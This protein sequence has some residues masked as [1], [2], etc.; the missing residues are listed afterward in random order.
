MDTDYRWGAGEEMQAM[1]VVVRS[2]SPSGPMRDSHV[3]AL[4]RSAGRYAM[5]ATFGVTPLDDDRGTVWIEAEGCADSECA[6]VLTRQ[7]ALVGF[8]RAETVVL[9]MFR[10]RACATVQCDNPLETCRPSDGRCRTAVVVTTE[11]PRFGAD[12]GSDPGVD[13]GVDAG[14]D[15]AVDTSVD[16]G[17]IMDVPRCLAPSVSCGSVCVDTQTDSVHCGACGRACSA[18]QTCSAGTCVCPTNRTLCSGIC[19]DI[20]TDSSNCGACGTPCTT[21]ACSAGR[22]PG[23]M[24]VQRS[25]TGTP[26]PAGCGLVAIVGGTFTMG[27]PT[28]CTR[29]PDATCAVDAAPEQSGITVG[30]FTLDAYEVTVDRFRAFWRERE[31]SASPTVLRANPIRYRNNPSIAWGDAAQDPLPLNSLCNW[32]MTDANVA[33]H[34]MNCF[35]W[36]LAQ[37]FCAWDGGRLPTEAEW[38]Y[39]ARGRT[40]SGLVTGRLYPWGSTPPS[41]ACDLAHWNN[42]PGTDGRR[43]RRVDAFAASASLYGLAGSVWEWTAD[44]HG[45]YPSCRASTTNPLCSNSATGRR[46]AR[47]GSWNLIDEVQN[48]RSASRGTDWPA[49]RGFHVGIRCARDAP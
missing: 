32:S 18:S 41:A 26:T 39:A 1:R 15:A 7:R 40:V 23:P 19:V 22:C 49:L 16:A 38:E 46:V 29:T 10:A 47:G 34:P 42:C 24:S 12:A 48:L 45:L 35:D 30:N 14:V 11:L 28:S 20:S 44:N 13:T 3:Y 17:F 43:T 2:G 37:E 5:P 33:A 21:G 31:A 25:C 36:W 8:A 6:R 4:G 27:V 9:R